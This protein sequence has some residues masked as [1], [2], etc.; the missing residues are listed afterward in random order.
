MK[1]GLPDARVT[2]L[3]SVSRKPKSVAMVLNCDGVINFIIG[4]KVFRLS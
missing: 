2:I 1:K 3:A 4:A